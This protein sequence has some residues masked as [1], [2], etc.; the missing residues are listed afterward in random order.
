MLIMIVKQ[1]IMDFKNFGYT[2]VEDKEL[3]EMEDIRAWLRTID[4]AIWI[5]PVERYIEKVFV[6]LTFIGWWSPG[7]EHEE[8]FPIYDDTYKEA[9]RTAL[10]EIYEN[11]ENSKL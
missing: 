3:Q 5:E 4:I 9:L 2:P 7:G 8:D 11:L 10:E 1:L 6:R